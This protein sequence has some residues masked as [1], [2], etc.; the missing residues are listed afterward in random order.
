[1]GSEPAGEAARRRIPGSGTW[2]RGFYWPRKGITSTSVD[3]PLVV[4]VTQR[5]PHCRV[6]VWP[7]Y[8]TLHES[9]GMTVPNLT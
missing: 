3:S 1:M 8:V 2:Q 9:L 6:E 7:L 5:E 4:P